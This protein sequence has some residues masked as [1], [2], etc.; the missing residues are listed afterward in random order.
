MLEAHGAIILSP[1]EKSRLTAQ[2]FDPSSTGVKKSLVGKSAQLIADAS[3]ISRGK[4]A[5][6]IVV[7]IKQ[8]EL[9]GPYGHEKLAPVLSLCT[10][11]DE[12][13]GLQVCNRILINQGHG[14]TAVIYTEDHE[15]IQQ[16]GSEIPASRILV[17]APAAQGCIGIGTGL[18]PSFTLGCGTFG[19]N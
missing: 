9:H 2:V 1:D 5:R 12:T 17:N 4:D 19:G 8:R 14:H 7:P 10:V 15:L 16:F 6:L 18:V 13:E 11:N 3:Q